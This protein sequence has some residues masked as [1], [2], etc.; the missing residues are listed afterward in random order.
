MKGQGKVQLHGARQRKSK[1]IALTSRKGWKTKGLQAKPSDC[2][3]NGIAQSGYFPFWKSST[4]TTLGSFRSQGKVDY[5]SIVCCV[6]GVPVNDIIA[7]RPPYCPQMRPPPIKRPT[8]TQKIKNNYLAR[9]F[10]TCDRTCILDLSF[11]K[12]CEALNPSNSPGLG[13]RE[14][15]R[16]RN[17]LNTN[18]RDCRI[19]P[20]C[21]P[22]AMGT[23][24]FD[25]LRLQKCGDW[26]ADTTF[27]N[28]F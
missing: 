8:T 19:P 22:F 20:H 5:V 7:T 11:Y 3:G 14:S 18:S 2:L 24:R 4:T 21:R 27:R 9:P 1:E 12:F 16:G 26:A 28:K 13:T 15:A 6:C 17:P 23:L 10:S 25:T